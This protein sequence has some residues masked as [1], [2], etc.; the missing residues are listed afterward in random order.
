MKKF[1]TMVFLLVISA[2]MLYAG[3]EL[4]TLWEKS[5]SQ[6]TMPKWFDTQNYTRG[7]AYGKVGGNDHLY[8]V[9]RFGGNFIYI[10]DAATGD[11]LGLLDNSGITGGTYHVSDV[12]VSQDGVIFVCN[13]AVGGTFKVYKWTDETVAPVEVIA[14]DATGKRLGDKMTVTG[15][16]ADN[17]LAI[18]AASANSN[19]VVKFST[20]DNGATFTADMVDIG[21]TGG[22]ASVDLVPGG[23]GDF[24]Y[25]ATGKH[26]FKFT[27]TGTQL[28]EVP[29]TVVSTGSNAIRF[30]TTTGN[31]EY[32][33]TFQYGAG[34]ENARVVKVPN[35]ELA[36]AAS[37]SLT[38]S[39]G[40]NSNANGTGDVAVKDNGDGTFNIFVLSTNNGLGA[41]KIKFPIPPIDPINMTLNWEANI[42]NYPFFKNDNNTRG[43]GYNPM[44]DHI[45]VAS[46]TGGTFICALDASNGAVVDTLDMTGVSGGTLALMKVVA[47]A[48][49]VVYACNL[50]LANGEFKIY[51]WENEGAVPTVAF[52]GTVTGRTGDAF[53]LSGD[54]LNT[55]LYASG[56]QSTKIEVFTTADGINFT[57]GT[58]IPVA[59]GAA[60][61]GMSAVTTAVN[62]DLWING[63]GT[64]LQHIAA[65]GAVITAVDGAIIASSWMNCAYIEA[66]NG[67]KL[68]A[69][70][71]NNVAGDIRKLQVWDIYGSE[72]NPVLWATGETGFIEF[73]NGNGAGEILAKDNNDGTFTVF[74]L[75]TNNAIASWTLQIPEVISVMTIAEA[76]VDANG[77]FVPDLLG[78][79][80]TIKGIITTPNYSSGTQYYMQDATAGIQVYGGSSMRLDFN[81]GDEVMITGK[82]DQYRGAT[83]IVQFTAET[84]KILTTGNAVDPTVTTIGALAENVEGMLLKLERVWMIDPAQWPAEGSNSNVDITDGIDTTY[85]FIDKETDLDG[86]TPPTGKFDLIA[87]CEQYTTSIPPN[88]GYSLRGT[89]REHFIPIPLVELP[90]FEGATDGDFDLVW[91]FNTSSEG[92]T[93]TIADSTGSAW[94]SHVLVFEDS[95]YTGLI[96]VKDALFKDYTIEADIFLVGEAVP[97]FSLYTGIGIKMA[98]D[99]FKY[100]R[101]VFRNST[102]SDHGQLRLQGYDGANWH[103]LRYWNPGVDFEPLQTGWHNFKVTVVGNQFWA[104]MDGKLLPGCPYEDD[105][106]I[107][108]E[109]YPGIYKYNTG[110]GTVI[111]DN[112]QVYEPFVPPP[113]EPE[114]LF[115]LWAKTQAAGTF[116]DYISTQ[117]YTRGLAYGKV[118]GADRV[119][120]VTRWGDHRVVIHDAVTGDSLGVIPK[121]PQAEGVGLFHL[122]AIDV[123]DDGM[124][125]VSNMSLTSD[126]ASPFRVYSWTSET[127]DAA[128]A[129][130]Y[131]AG[132][133]RMGDMIS[134]YGSASDNSLVIYAAVS[135]GNKFVK[136]T[137][138]DN[139]ATFTP[140]VIELPS[141]NFGSLPNIAQTKDGNLYI[142]SYGRYLFRYDPITSLMD[143]VSSEVVGSGAT[144]IKYYA[145][146]DKEYLIVYYPDVPGAGDAEKMHI[147]DITD[148]PKKALAVY[149]SSSI[150]SVT[151]GN[152]TG[153]VDVMPIANDKQL[154]FIL[155]TNNG[156]AAFSNSAD[157]VITTLDTLF[158]GDT[159]TLH[160]NPF[161]AG[162]I[163]GTNE[164]GDIGKYQRFDFNPGDQLHGF[165]LYFALKEVVNDPDTL[166]LV[167]K[168]VGE[169]GMPG[170]TIA[171]M[172]TTTDK[173]DTTMMGNVFFLDNPI[174]LDSSIFIG[175]EWSTMADDQFALFA[176]QNGEGEKA[177]RAWEKFSDGN[178]NDFLGVLRPDFSWGVDVDLWIASY[179]KK[180]LPTSIDKLTTNSI[181]NGYRLSQNY[182]NPFNP[183]TMID[184]A[185][186]ENADVEIN[187][188]NILGQKVAEVFRGRLNA[189]YHKFEFTAKHLTSG[190]YIYK[191]KANHFESVKKMTI[192]K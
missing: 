68:V 67:A 188:Y 164:Y 37:Y 22:S 161:G 80:V 102:A 115:P 44:T 17:S 7:F 175:F 21:M 81:A 145:T 153:S 38:P 8:V 11:S 89:F 60:R 149:Y 87:V 139:G 54:S 70:N 18:W 57:P 10:L 113:P 20:T 142:K 52:A 185:I 135:A 45:L 40:S 98:H 35:G 1:L 187:V 167:I 178:Y 182:P 157:F 128:T 74:Q 111:F 186:P 125:F 189:G 110:L 55:I 150:G 176:D 93:L 151:N 25:N 155:G 28:G 165:K 95:A 120:V 129:I 138:A 24:Y 12:G 61:G 90:L 27:A 30:I 127:A 32:V 130:S 184:L 134:V 66:P 173:L 53:T 183:S 82:I 73:P 33:V 56:S 16:A 23:S 147:V 86:W 162:Y 108:T 84:V 123:S 114:K 13:L 152:G 71:A 19:Q 105:S 160:P 154:F 169:N 168:L 3:V 131:D 96:H 42:D 101:M 34:N 141:G 116:P 146:T 121:P 166:D 137:T 41:Y 26:V 118:N 104:F 5:A 47:D 51:R 6:A 91:D 99:E 171:M 117:N 77:D 112:F 83:E 107:L 36:N 92:G 103:T 156:V 143:T 119:Y 85:V 124:I 172:K 75:T 181:P 9:S 43:I 4:T 180:A 76:K 59:S 140:E 58:P 163:V 148:G 106:P 72:S 136:F 88:N 2:N 94:G 63:T 15:S 31:L 64:Q 49:G 179:Y 50:T 190:I 191:V 79:E 65:D 62:S 29:G 158:Y 97:D 69:V 170:E 100:Y 133:G 122:N 159:A 126:A 109:G 78:Q 46:R 177:N 132:L 14:Y 48:K 39:L 174:T 144:K 192:L